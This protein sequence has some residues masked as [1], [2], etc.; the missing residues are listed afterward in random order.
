MMAFMI[1]VVL[2]AYNEEAVVGRLIDEIQSV[3]R[4]TGLPFEIVLVDDASEDKTAEIA[5]SKG[6]RILRHEKNRGA[7]ASARTGIESA[8]G[9]IVVTMDAD[10]SYSPGNIPEMLRFIP[11]YDQVIGVRNKEFGKT[12]FL[13]MAVKRLLFLLASLTSGYAIPDLNSGLRVFKR[14]LIGPFLSSFPDRFSY[15]STMTLSFLYNGH[16]VKFVPIDYF[17]RIG[18]SKFKIFKDTLGIV[19]VIL[20]AKRKLK[21]CPD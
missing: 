4:E 17:P 19:L 14:E 12:G 20:Q 10:G 18:K 15:V 21:K 11:S 1:S 5:Q 13:R 8:Q 6:A 2:P 7:G 16:A 3:M 9:D